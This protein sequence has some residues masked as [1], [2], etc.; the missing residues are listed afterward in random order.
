MRTLLLTDRDGRLLTIKELSL[1]WLAIAFFATLFL[2]PSMPVINNITIG[3]IALLCF[4]YN[5]VKEKGQLLRSRPAVICMLL[6]FALEL[7]SAAVSV[8]QHRAWFVIGVRSSLLIFPLSLGLIT[9]HGVLRR[10]ILLAYVVILLLVSLC[11]LTDAIHRAWIRHDTQWLYDD[12]LTLLIGRTS[13]YMALLV[14]LAIAG[15]ASLLES[16]FAAG[17]AKWA[18]YGC[19]GFFLL[20]HFLLASRISMFYLYTTIVLYVAIR[21][22]N[23]QKPGRKIATL[24]GVVVLVGASLIV[25]P[26]TLNRFRQLQYT[27]YDY[28]SRGMESHYNMAVTP[29][30]W[31]SANFRLAVWAC[32]LALAEKHPVTGVPLGDKQ[33]RLME[34]YKA[35]DFMFAYTRHR[36]LHST[37]LDVLVNTG[38]PGL[39]I[40]L[41]GYLVFPVLTA[42]KNKDWLSLVMVGA[43]ATAMTTETWI[44][45]SFGTIGLAFWLSLIGAWGKPKPSLPLKPPLLPIVPQV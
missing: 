3:A 38:I 17:R 34:E 29:D 20:F 23:G 45:G 40:F 30:Q 33:A 27:H 35:R 22:I 25:F 16:G 36:N 24:A 26:K 28:H 13:V 11:C 18:A 5:P 12:S 10:R 15:L 9:V 6:F 14:V 8:D 7:V 21:M 43:F 32:G 39:A 37:W 19:I 2:P 31:N 41:L 1:Y 4:G 44:D 42:I